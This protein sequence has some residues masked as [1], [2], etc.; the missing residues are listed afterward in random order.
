MP[1]WP[2]PQ[3]S[4]WRLG[5]VL[6]ACSGEHGVPGTPD[7][8]SPTARRRGN[9]GGALGRSVPTPAGP[10]RLEKVAVAYD[11]AGRGDGGFNDLAYNGAKRAADELGAELIEVTAKPD[12]TDA[13]RAERLRLLAE[14]GYDP[15]VA[16]G[17][18][19]RRSAGH[20]GR[21]VPGHLVRHRG[22]RHRRRSQRRR[23]SRSRRSRAPSWWAWRR[24]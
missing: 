7:A 17:F 11:L 15:I 5:L 6:A 23:A 16:V 20:G 10:P 4:R 22:R 14:S 3:S 13:D 2:R 21:R 12:D 9:G 19:L 8:A 1:R 24:P 18:T